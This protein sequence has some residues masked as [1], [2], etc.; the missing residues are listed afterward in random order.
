MDIRP[1][2]DTNTATV[3]YV[4][5]DGKTCAIIDSVL[6]YDL[7]T[8]RSSTA[9]ADQIVAYVTAHGLKVEWILETHIHADH[10]TAADYLKGKLG[11]KTAIGNKI[12]EALAY[13]VPKFAINDTPLDGS[14]FDKLWKDGERFSIGTL[15]AE[16]LFTPGHT[17]VCLCYHIGDAVF[18][19]DTIFMPNVGTARADFP[20]GDA[21]TLY[22]SIKKI[23]AL[24]DATRLFMCHDYPPKG[25]TPSWETTVGE[26]KKKNIFVSDSVSEAEYVQKRRARDETLAAPRLLTPS[27][28]ANLRAGKIS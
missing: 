27:L 28:K 9:F 25:N 5:S 14:Q 6:D 16:V 20:G 12:T 3:S 22:R 24:P 15:K 17:P 13:W 18:V 26:Q 4:V 7:A 21:A 19:G 10:L 8:G 2:F 11:G 1:F 23:L